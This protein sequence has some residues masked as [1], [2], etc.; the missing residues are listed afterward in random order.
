MTDCDTTI[1]GRVLDRIRHRGTPDCQ[2]E[3]GSFEGSTLAANRLP[4]ISSPF[5][6]QPVYSSDKSTALV[7]NGEIYNHRQLGRSVAVPNSGPDKGGDGPAL[8]ALLS[9]RGPHGLPDLEGMFAIVWVDKSR[10]R[11]YAARDFVGIKPLYYAWCDSSLLFASEIKALADEDKVTEIHEV[12]PGTYVEIGWDAHGKPRFIGENTYFHASNIVSEPTTIP[13]IRE[14]IEKAVDLCVNYGGKVGVYLSGGVD[15]SGVYAIAKRFHPSVTAL[16]LNGPKGIDGPVARRFVRSLGEEPVTRNCPNE[17]ELFALIQDTIRITESFEPNVVRQSSV[18]RYIAL[19]AKD[20]GIEVILCG[21]GADEIFC[22]YPEFSAMDVRWHEMRLKFLHDLSRTQLQR[23]DRMSM[24]LTTEVRVPYLFKALILLALAQRAKDFF[25][26]IVD[27]E[28][29]NKFCLRQSLAGYVPE[30]IRWRPKV[31]LSEG[32]GLGGNDPATGMFSSL[33]NAQMSSGEF[34]N[35]QEAFP[36]WHISTR[37]EAYYFQF[38]HQMGY[39]K[40]KFMQRRVFANVT[41]S[42]SS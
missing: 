23:V 32:V 29:T 31:V 21:E 36:R 1:V 13:A 24:W 20:A 38:F 40:A 22:G 4:I 14:G 27:G 16:V 41:N 17:E 11:A 5:Q 30:E 33:V 25:L 10:Q 18:Q 7:F 42:M 19:L 8:A 15:S 12:N 28:L 39:S 26:R 2:H 9:A 3:I 35:I 34:L 37:E 6:S